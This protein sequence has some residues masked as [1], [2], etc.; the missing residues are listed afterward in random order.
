M[1]TAALVEMVPEDSGTKPAKGSGGQTDAD[2]DAVINAARGG[3]N[4]A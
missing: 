4:A 3:Q 1:Y 2:L